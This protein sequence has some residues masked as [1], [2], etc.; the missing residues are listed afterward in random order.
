MF[1]HTVEGCACQGKR[2]PGC[3]QVKCYGAYNRD[4]SRKS[5]LD[6]LCRTC[7]RAKNETYRRNHAEE[8]RARARAYHR[9]H[10]EAASVRHKAWQQKNPEYDRAYKRA[11][12]EAHPERFREYYEAN[13]GKLSEQN[14]AWR[15]DNSEHCYARDK[16]YREAH[17]EQ[18]RGWSRS[19]TRNNPERVAATK[20]NRRARKTQ[21]GGSFTQQEWQ[22]LKARYDYAC[23]RCGRQEPEITL[24]ADHVVPIAKGGTSD[25]S[26]IQPL[27][28]P[29]NTGKGTKSIDYRHDK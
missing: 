25:I 10:A 21:A 11:Q 26:N 17:A 1:E 28:R 13:R 9:A 12:R 24:T 22:D 8:E 27:C 20:A 2:C 3:E 16:A 7:Q 23:L 4:S 15:Q 19:W 14:R 29:C 18:Y 6:A 5:G